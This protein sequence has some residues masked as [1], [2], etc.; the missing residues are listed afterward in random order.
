LSLRIDRVSGRR[1]T[2]RFVDVPW[3]LYGDSSNTWVPP[4]RVVVRDALD[5]RKNPFYRDADLALFISLRDGQPIGR[6]AAIENRAHNRHHGDRVGFFGFF[7]CANDREASDA[8]FRK[9]GAW[10]AK[11]GLTSIRGPVSP[12]MNHESGLLVDGCDLRSFVMTPWHPPYCGELVEGAGFSGAQDL[13]GYWIPADGDDRVPERI[14]RLAERTRRRTGVTFRTLDVGVLEREARLVLDLYCD[15]WSD[16]WGFVPPAWDEFWHTAK[17]LK[18][19]LSPEFS[20]VAEVEGEIVGF[21]MVARDLNEVLAGNPSG[22]LWPHQVLRLLTGLPKV[23]SGR[24]VLLGMRPEYRNRGL[25]PLFAWE[26]ARRG[27]EGGYE[28]AEASWILADNEAL[29]APLEAMG[30]PSSKRWRIYEKA[31]ELPPGEASATR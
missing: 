17:D 14:Q 15:A 4:L 21:M 19:V 3:R 27:R 30:I 10:L 13:L 2:A 11:R 22:R 24:I 6:V 18:S 29:T 31:L 25:F 20:F 7:D 9:A 26:A 8:L 28:G 16:N 12:S 5:T 1:G 23:R